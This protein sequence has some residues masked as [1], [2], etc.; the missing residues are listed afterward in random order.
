LKTYIYLKEVTGSDS[1]NIVR[2][3]DPHIAEGIVFRYQ[4]SNHLGSVGL[5]LDEDANIISYEEYHPMYYSFS[6]N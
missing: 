1:R 6:C 4:Y 2:S 5:E 3:A